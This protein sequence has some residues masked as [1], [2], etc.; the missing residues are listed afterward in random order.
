MNYYIVDGNFIAQVKKTKDEIIIKIGNPNVK[1][2]PRVKIEIQKD[3]KT[4][5]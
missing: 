2:G 4:L 3:E 5:R 1:Q